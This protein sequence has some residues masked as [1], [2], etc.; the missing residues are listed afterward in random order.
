[1]VSKLSGY[2]SEHNIQL[3]IELELK[4]LYLDNNCLMDNYSKRF[5][6][7]HSDMIQED[8]ASE[9]LQEWGKNIQLGR[10]CILL[11]LR[12]GNFH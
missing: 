6:Q 12:F 3:H 1:M 9:K 8:I 4:C 11:S 7:F 2:P 10:E 5:F